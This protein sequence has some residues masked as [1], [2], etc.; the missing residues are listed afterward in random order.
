[1]RKTHL[2]L[3]VGVAATILIHGALKRKEENYGGSC[4]SIDDGRYV[5]EVTGKAAASLF[6]VRRRLYAAA[7]A[8]FISFA[9][10]IT[11]WFEGDAAQFSRSGS[12]VTVFALLGESLLGEGVSRLNRQMRRSHG[13]YYTLWRA[14]CAIAAVLGTLVWGY[15][16]LLHANLMPEPVPQPQICMQTN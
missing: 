5:P 6:E 13:S 11:W 4:D 9:W 10:S 8:V 7:I 14:V 16:D 2:S 15:G 3:I 12:V 1:M